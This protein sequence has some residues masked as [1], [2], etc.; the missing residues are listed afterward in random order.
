MDA[1]KS[2]YPEDDKWKDFQMKPQIFLELNKYQLERLW[3]DLQM[4]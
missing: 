1:P 3:M 2:I 4:E